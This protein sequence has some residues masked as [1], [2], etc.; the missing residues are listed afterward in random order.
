M[1]AI[2]DINAVKAFIGVHEDIG[3]QEDIGEQEDRVLLLGIEDGQ[4]N[5]IWE[6]LIQQTGGIQQGEKLDFSAIISV[7]EGVIDFL[8]TGLSLTDAQV[9]PILKYEPVGK[10]VLDDAESL[11]EGGLL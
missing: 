9:S 10:D 8:L 6:N 1:L 11:D 2:A 4:D 3:V 7:R 5:Y